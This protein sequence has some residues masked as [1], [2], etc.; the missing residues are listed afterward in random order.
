MRRYI[1]SSSSAPIGREISKEEKL[2]LDNDKGL[3]NM[4]EHMAETNQLGEK[5]KTYL[6]QRFG[7]GE[8]LTTARDWQYDTRLGSKLTPEARERIYPTNKKEVTI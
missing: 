2:L 4:L 7:S 1:R 3:R 5:S 8:K 6:N